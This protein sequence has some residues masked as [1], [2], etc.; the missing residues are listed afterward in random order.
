MDTT[1]R[2]SKCGEVKAL[3]AFG[4]NG[5]GGLRRECRGC[6][7]VCRAAYYSANAEKVKARVAAYRASN[8]E[9]IKAREATYRA[10]NAEKV[11]AYGAACCS[12]LADAYVGKLLRRSFPELQD[13]PPELIEVK[14]QLTHQKRTVKKIDA[15]LNRKKHHDSTEQV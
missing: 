8:A 10:A 3:G 15:H 5:R 4:S 6:R 7:A 14:R 13:I 11:K 1:K 2:C 9:K 12:G